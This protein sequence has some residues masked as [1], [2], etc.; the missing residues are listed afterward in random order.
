MLIE[1]KIKICPCNPTGRGI[2]LKIRGLWVRI[3]PW[4]PIE[5]KLLNLLLERID[6][7][8]KIWYNNIIDGWN[9]YGTGQIN[10]ICTSLVH[11]GGNW[12]SKKRFQCDW[13]NATVLNIILGEFNLMDRT[14]AK[15]AGWRFDS[16]NSAM[17]SNM[18]K[19]SE[20]G[21]KLIKG[22]T[23]APLYIHWNTLI[24]IILSTEKYNIR[25]GIGQRLVEIL[26]YKN[27]RIL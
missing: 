15:V 22:H 24:V 23:C 17:I 9:R 19:Q 11:C 10:K 7:T 12:T 26:P 14:V 16:F 13:L 1:V 6:F 27:Y 21:Y 20:C 25:L 5:K 4:A 18:L 2:G 3:S 8:R